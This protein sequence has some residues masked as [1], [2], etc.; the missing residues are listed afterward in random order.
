MS[1]GLDVDKQRCEQS[2]GRTMNAGP[3]CHNDFDRRSFL[4]AGALGAVAM[5]MEGCAAISEP[6]PGLKVE[7]PI[8]HNRTLPG[9]IDA[10]I[11]VV[12]GNPDLKPG[13]PE[14]DKLMTAE[15][16]VVAERVRKE[17]REAGIGY[18]FAMGHR[19]GQMD[20]P[21]GIASSLRV[22]DLVPGMHVIG[23]AEPHRTSRKHLREVERQI[24]RERARLV[25]FKIYLGYVQ[26]EASHPG[27]QPYYRIAERYRL[28][29][30]FHTGDTWS[31][32][33][34]VK[35]A[36]PLSVDEV[37]TDHPNVRFVLAHFG[38]PWMKDAAE[39]LFKNDNVW[40]DLS[41][42]YVGDEKMLEAA[43]QEGKFGDL[44]NALAYAEKYDRILYGSDWPLAPMRVYRRYIESVI[45]P[46]HHEKVFRANAEKLFLT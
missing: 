5:I 13:V 45:P 28:P 17:M 15:P 33:A 31:Y 36:H 4:R 1:F 12:F 3:K 44:R 40:A 6:K 16:A 19:N 38:N 23:I 26:A 2:P 8:S 9:G 34:K 21:L 22:A 46:K 10:H 27:Y 24:E 14:T 32:K 25:A 35:Y 43:I 39:V 37:A 11:H 42:L 41:G 18:V 29:V 30:I 20:D 7:K